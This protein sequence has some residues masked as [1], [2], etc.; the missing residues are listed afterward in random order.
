MGFLSIASRPVALF[1]SLSIRNDAKNAISRQESIFNELI[2]KGRKTL[3]GKE[4]GFQGIRNYTDYRNQVPLTDYENLKKYIVRSAKGEKDILWPG[5]PI[6]FAKTS[7]T[8]SGSKHIP[9]TADSIHNHIR[10]ARNALLFYMHRSGNYRFA[11][12]KMIFL[13]GS[14]ELDKHGVIPSGRLSGIVAHHVPS[15]L[16]KNRM[17]SWQTN[18]IGDW[19]AKVDKVV[20]ETLKEKMSLISGIPSW[21][22]IYFEKIVDSTGKTVGEAF[23]DF[24]LLVY[25][26]L[27]FEPYRKV[28][29]Q[30]IGRPVDSI[31]TYPAS[32]GFIAFQDAGTEDGML[33]NINS[34]IFYEFIPVEKYGE[35]E[36]ERLPLEA[37]ETGRD[38]AL[39]LS[40]NAGLWA[41]SIGDTV[42]FVSKSPYRIKVTGRVSQFI[43]AFGEHVIASEVEDALAETCNETRVGVDEFTVAPQ[44]NPA[45]G[46]PHHEWVIEFSAPPT[47]LDNFALT[48]DHAL[49]K[50]NDY[51]NDL[52]EGNILSPLKITI[53]E[54]GTFTAYLK[55]KGL[56]G[57]QNKVI[58]VS[59]NRELVHA[60][61]DFAG[62]MN[63]QTG[64]HPGT[65]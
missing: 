15:Y 50:R 44:V 63:R 60:L 22:R 34:G 9:I 59:D 47:D 1:A 19:E 36:A 33:L 52:V 3:Y 17:P 42:R 51:Y 49:R 11:D 39:I 64:S 21:L 31:E 12:H 25:G 65:L 57:G 56:L 46:L 10:T 4:F 30:L 32:E 24:S 26:G 27:S 38:Y 7:G 6:Y 28:F 14:P 35:P 43:S 2:R 13:Q 37:V 23:P 62:K 20:E 53:L 58:H 54:K 55:W 40:S 48:L 29:E 18:C 8:T 16:Q 41:Y 5:K 45:H 61:I